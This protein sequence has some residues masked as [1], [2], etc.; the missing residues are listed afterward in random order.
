MVIWITP[1]QA[2]LHV[3]PETS[4]GLPPIVVFAAPGFH[5]VVNGTHG[6]G[7]STPSA[8][9]VAAATVGFDRLV[10]IPNG[11]TLTIGAKSVIVA[12]GRPSII[13]RGVG[14][15][16]NVDGAIPKLHWSMAPMTAFSPMTCPS[17][18]RSLDRGRQLA[19]RRGHEADDVVV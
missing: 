1:P 18:L 5:G 9:L 7:V 10:H 3:D 14:S 17:L 16:I 13:T 11:G 12:A 19:P 15:G 6:I 4:A 2:Q 8:A